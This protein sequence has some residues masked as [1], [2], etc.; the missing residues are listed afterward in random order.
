MYS[1]RHTDAIRFLLLGENDNEEMRLLI[2]PRDGQS[3]EIKYLGLTFAEVQERLE[4]KWQRVI[5]LEE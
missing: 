5:S 4:K 3:P 2:V 1:S